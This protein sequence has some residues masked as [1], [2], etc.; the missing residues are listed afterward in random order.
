MSFSL[1]ITERERKKEKK[2]A[3]PVQSGPSQMT[4]REEVIKPDGQCRTLEKEKKKKI[5]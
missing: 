4:D 5:K 2:K 3:S 1:L